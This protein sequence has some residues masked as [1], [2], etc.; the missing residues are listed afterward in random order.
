MDIIKANSCTGTFIAFKGFSRTSIP[1][2]MEI[3]DVVNVKIDVINT[4]TRKRVE[5]NIHR[6]IPSS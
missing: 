6:L 1:S 4:N 3:G 2:V 5:I